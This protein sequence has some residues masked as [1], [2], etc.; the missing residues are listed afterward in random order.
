[1]LQEENSRISMN[2]VKK[3]SKDRMKME[4][5]NAKT[6][7]EP[8]NNKFP[9]MVIYIQINQIVQEVCREKVSALD[10]VKGVKSYK[11]T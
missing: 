7:K 9:N 3:Y 1:M 4:Y 11:E 6:R 10:L 5:T 8:K 2:R